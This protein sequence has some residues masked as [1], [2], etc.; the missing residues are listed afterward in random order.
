MAAIETQLNLGK[1]L[2]IAFSEGVRNQISQDFRDWEMVMRHKSGEPNGRQLNF[3]FQTSFG[4]AAIQY[5]APNQREFPT[6]QQITT[7]EHTARYKEAD[8]TVEIEYNLWNRARKSPAKYAEPLA[9]EIQS[10]TTASKRRLAAD[11]YGD[12]T[13]VVIQAAGA[14]SIVGGKTVVTQDAASSARGHVGWAEYGDLLVPRNADGTAANPT[15]AS[16]TFSHYRV[17]DKSRSPIVGGSDTVTLAAIGT[18]GLVKTVTA[19]GL[20]AGDV[21]YRVG[22]QTGALNALDLTASI[23]DYGTATEVLA[24]LESL[25]SNDGR[26]IHGITMSGASAGS[27]VDAAAAPLDSTLIQQLMDQAKIR[28]GQ[29]AYSWKMLAM[30]PEAHSS[31]VEARE[32]DRRFH[33]VEDNKRGIRFFA[34]Q[35]GNDTLE[36]YT[37]EFIPKKRSYALPESKAG[38]KVIEFHGTDF[39]TVKVNDSSAFNLKPANAGGHERTVVTYMEALL[40]LIVKHPAAIGKLVNFS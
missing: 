28:V 18:D 25:V 39:E 26:V 37:T 6:S 36:C 40:C 16:G 33:T 30:A 22:Q 38:Q 17:D 9:L 19:T 14:G 4:P 10:K 34:Y 1:F 31:L 35:H 24:G 32:T 11:F 20:T 23:V 2:E 21:L 5:R 12:G 3:L 8:V 15:L 7:S 13:G 27:V 29:G